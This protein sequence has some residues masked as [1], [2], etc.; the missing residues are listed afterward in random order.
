M[1]KPIYLFVCSSSDFSKSEN[2]SNLQYAG[3]VLNLAKSG[4]VD[5]DVSTFTG[6]FIVVNACNEDE[7]KYLRLLNLDNCLKI[8]VLRKSESIKSPWITQQNIK[9]DY[10]IKQ[11]QVE[12]LKEAKT[13]IDVLNILKFLDMS[14]KRPHSDAKFIWSKIKSA[15]PFLSVFFDKIIH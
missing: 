14:R 13:K 12:V 9:Y 1:S 6:D 4:L 3:R 2:I 5:A 8:C 7:M 10:I 11:N 15:I